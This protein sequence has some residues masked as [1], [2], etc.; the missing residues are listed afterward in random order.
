[1]TLQLPGI[2]S[3]D[4]SPCI[5]PTPSSGECAIPPSTTRGTYRHRHTH[6]ENL[7][8]AGK[9]GVTETNHRSPDPPHTYSEGNGCVAFL[10]FSEMCVTVKGKAPTEV[11]TA[12]LSSCSGDNPSP[13]GGP[14]SSNLDDSSAL[15]STH[16]RSP[17]EVWLLV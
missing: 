15:C 11:D 17:L 12:P 16:L 3:K 10:A 7:L 6:T 8:E 9:S 14:S 2:T 1:M 5:H 13:L 4:Q